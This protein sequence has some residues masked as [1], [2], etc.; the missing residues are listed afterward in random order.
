[1]TVTGLPDR[2]LADGL[3]T[4]D[5]TDVVERMAALGPAIAARSAEY[6]LSASFP[7]ENWNDF[8]A[9][10]LLGICI[11]RDDGG[12]GADFVGYAL[13]AEELGRHCT[14][15]A[16]TFNMHVA[17][18]LLTG[19]IADDMTLTVDER[20]VLHERRSA[21]RRGVVDRHHIHSQPFSEG[22]A[23]GATTGFATKAVPV[24]GGYRVTG[25]KIF[26]SL[27][28][29]ADINNVVCVVDGDPR[30]RLL[31][32]PADADGIEL[33]GTWDPLGMRATDSRNLVM[34]D[35]FVPAEHE[36]IPPGMFDQA[37][38]RWP[39]FYM[40]LSFAYLGLMRAIMDDTAAYLIGD[41]GP[42]ARRS[43]PIKQQGWA[44]MNLVY[45]QAQALCYRVLGE[46]GVDPSSDAV[47]RAWASMVTTMEGA[48]TLAS[49]AI[50]ICG[51]RSML[52]P[53]RLE[54]HYRD[55]RCGATMLPWSVEVCLDRLG[56]AGLFPDESELSA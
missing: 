27:S 17:T 28:S 39:Y 45:E 19:Q 1:M 4:P 23:A 7:T 43:H 44:S 55:A 56:R 24:D 2:L 54:Q 32:V 18:T 21:L 10:G 9:N 15:T 6:D 37:A 29:A 14:A 34:T 51:G 46:V 33:E 11:P 12:L 40:T 52:R 36:W 8:A 22:A 3:M 5:R 38:A 13:A 16:L 31:G 49:T 35:V 50:R 53:S 26:A 41:G 47:R 48:P 42:T 25:R 20:R 30:I